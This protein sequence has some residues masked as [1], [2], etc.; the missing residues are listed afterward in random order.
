MFLCDVSDRR[1]LRARSESNHGDWIQLREKDGYSSDEMVTLY[2]NSKLKMFFTQTVLVL[3][4]LDLNVGTYFNAVFTAV[5]RGWVG[6]GAS[7]CCGSL[8]TGR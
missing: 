3:A 7:P 8:A 4:R 2:Y 6:A 5:E 1:K